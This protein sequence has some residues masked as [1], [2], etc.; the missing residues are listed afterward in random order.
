DQIFN[1]AA[2]FHYV[3][4]KQARVPIVIRTPGGGG[5]SYGPT[6]S[7]SLEAHFMHTPGIKIA[8]PSNPADAKGL[9]K[10]AVR[11]DNPVLFVESKVL[12]PLKGE[13]PEGEHLVPFGQARVARPGGDVTIIAYSRMVLIALEAAQLLAQEGIEAEVVDLRTLRPLDTETLVQSVKKTNRAL[14]VEEGWRSFGVG[15]EV[16]ARIAEHAFDYLDAPIQRVATAEVPMPY[17]RNLE[18]AA[19][20]KVDDVIR[21][22]KNLLIPA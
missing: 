13:V 11:D 14:I 12:Y 19:L 7:Q 22:A 20:P 21:A 9:L 1:Q 3:Y 18:Q 15:A 2:K 10:T 6:H 4:G 5:R 8:V 17:A 16:A